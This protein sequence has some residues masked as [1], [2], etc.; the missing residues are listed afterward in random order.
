MSC[1]TSRIFIINNKKY[2]RMAGIIEIP[3]FQTL[4]RRARMIDFH[5]INSEITFLYS[6]ESIAAV[7]SFMIHTCKPSTT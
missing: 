4:S 5:A 1:R 7:D 2:I 6:V 3:S